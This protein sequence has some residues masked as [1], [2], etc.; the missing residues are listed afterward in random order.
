MISYKR[1]RADGQN[2]RFL[3]DFIIKSEQY[4]RV[5]NY[6]YNPNGID[7]DID[8]TTGLKVRVTDYPKSEDLVTINY[9]DLV[10]N[11]ISFYTPPKGTVYIE[12]ATTPEEFGSTLVQ[13]SVEDAEDAARRA[14][15]AADKAKDSE[16]A[17]KQSE[18]DAANSAAQAKVSETNAGVS[19]AAAANSADDALLSEQNA[20][21]SKVDAETAEANAV[22]AQGMAYKW[23]ENP[24]DVEVAPGEYSAHHW[25]IKSINA[26]GID[27]PTF[28]ADE[29]KAWVAHQTGNKWDEILG[30]PD[31]TNKKG[32]SITSP[33]GT[34]KDSVWTPIKTNPI[35]LP[36]D[37]G[38]ASGVSASAVDGFT[39]PDGITLTVPDGSVL[40][41]V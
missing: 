16:N 5:Y 13:P 1:F 20:Y 30:L 4:C 15:E 24:E 26:G 41:I 21:Q 19:A 27:T 11:S 12:V 7:G 22:T 8:P 28:P 32:Y 35:V 17:A 29:G 39:I 33:T 2:I 6:M 31:E 38:L 37:W 3:S 9:W 23:A 40:S 34:K 14:D 10:D 18:I 25:A 36:E